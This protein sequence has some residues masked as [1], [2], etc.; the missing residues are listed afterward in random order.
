MGRPDPPDSEEGESQDQL[1]HWLGHGRVLM[2]ASLRP[3][4][5][6]TNRHRTKEEQITVFI[7]HC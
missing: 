4:F 2:Q 3:L 5:Q 6:V 1:F 7:N